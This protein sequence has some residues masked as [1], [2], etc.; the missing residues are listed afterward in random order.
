MPEIIDP[1]F[2][3]TSPKRSYSMTEYERFGLVSRKRGS[4]IRAQQSFRRESEPVFVNV[5]GAQESTNAGIFKQSMGA[6]NGV[7]IGLSYPSARLHSLAEL[8]P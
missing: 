4:K 2:M 7:E 6:R 5:S 8:V 1:V 3:K